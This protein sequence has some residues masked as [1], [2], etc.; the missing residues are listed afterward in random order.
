MS[1]S[2]L[3]GTQNVESASDFEKPA[4]HLQLK[5]PCVFIQSPLK[6]ILIESPSSVHSFISKQKINWIILL[7]EVLVFD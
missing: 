3:L 6:H 4:W 2:S 7:P 5:E 1:T